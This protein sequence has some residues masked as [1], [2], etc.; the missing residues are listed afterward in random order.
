MKKRDIYLNSAFILL[1][2]VLYLINPLGMENHQRIVLSILVFVTCTWATS[3][4]DK[5]VACIILLLAFV[6]FGNTKPLTIISQVWG[7]TI[8]LIM[9][10]TLLSTGMMKTGLVERYLH[11]LLSKAGDSTLKL[12][13]ISY[14]LGIALIFLVPQAFARVIILGTIFNSIF[15]AGNE[16]EKR[17]KEVLIF[18]VFIAV[19]ITSMAFSNG[20]IVLNQAAIGFQ[21]GVANN[22]NPVHWFQMMSVPTL[23]TAVVTLFVIKIGFKNELSYFS[24]NMIKTREA[25]AKKENPRTEKIIV[26]M[27]LIIVVLWM[28]EPLHGLKAWLVTLAGIG[29]M[30]FLKVLELKDLKSIN[31]HFILFMVTVFTIGRGLG[32][33]G[34]TASIFNSL[35]KVLPDTGS[36][37]YLMILSIVVMVLHIFIG[38]S[39]A[40]LSVI[41][42]VILPLV[43]DLGY[44]PEIITL[45]A[46]IIVNIHFLLPYHHASVMIGTGKGFYSEKYMLRFGLIMTPITFALLYFVFFKYWQLLGLL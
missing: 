26:L 7:D 27:M 45:M 4:L 6:I 8:L 1:V 42:P 29:I 10:T 35:Q 15:V 23:I 38:S 37:G 20:D 43:V 39:L 13:I 34:V 31:L 30:F 12:L 44:R 2:I 17:A 41:L 32:E 22:L 28:T 33:A 40:T 18:N 16:Y 3:S 9:T 5:S 19:T 25:E 24:P 21:E 14:L 46:Y 11:K 36:L